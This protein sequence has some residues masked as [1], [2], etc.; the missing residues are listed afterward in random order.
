[1]RVLLLNTDTAEPFEIV[2][3]DRIAQLVIAPVASPELL[4]LDD[5][6][7]TARGAGGFGSSG[8]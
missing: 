2:P 4:E 6:D 1:V 3:G 5:L 8:R 7:Q